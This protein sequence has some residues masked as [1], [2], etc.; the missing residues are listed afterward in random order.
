MTDILNIILITI[1]VII[2]LFL[3]RKIK[4]IKSRHQKKLA[5]LYK[6]LSKLAEQKES[7]FE[8]LSLNSELEDAMTHA[9][10]RLNE[11]IFDLQMEVFRNIKQD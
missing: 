5:E 2:I 3:L 10:K 8:K 7:F 11:E 1:L 6:D 4:L 9:R